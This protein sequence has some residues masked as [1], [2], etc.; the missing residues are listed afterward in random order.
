MIP[1]STA[2]WDPHWFHQNGETFFDNHDVIN[3]LRLD[4]LNPNNTECQGREKCEVVDKNNCPFM[5]SYDNQLKSIDFDNLVAYCENIANDVKAIT[6]FEEEPII[7][8]LVYETPDNPCSERRSL[9][10]WFK[11]HGYLL[12]E[13]EKGESY[14]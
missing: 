6:K 10:K 13:F 3:G 14:D 2:K 12:E 1:F 8:L 11:S 7:I 4:I 5:E 9:Q